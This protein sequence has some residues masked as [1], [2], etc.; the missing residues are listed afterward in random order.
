[1]TNL[2]GLP[3]FNVAGGALPMPD[4]PPAPAAP[5]MHMVEVTNRNGFVIEDHF[6]GVSHIFR[7]NEPLSIPPAAAS[8]FF[9]WPG[10]GHVMR[11]HTCRRFGWNTPVHLARDP[12]RPHDLRSVADI[13]FGN[14]DIK[15]VEY[16]MVRRSGHNVPMPEDAD[17][18]DRPEMDARSSPP[19]ERQGDPEGGTRAG[20]G[21]HSREARKIDM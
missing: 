7:P 5:P 13:Y 2:P 1:M 6:D 16:E 18:A 10:E 20:G 4:P 3:P 21:R 19:M 14:I 8:H 17:L 12:T 15:T 11:L 9:G